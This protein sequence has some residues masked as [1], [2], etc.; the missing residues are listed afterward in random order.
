MKSLVALAFLFLFLVAMLRPLAPVLD[1]AANKSYFATVLCINKD[2]PDLECEGKCVLMQRLK[3]AMGEEEPLPT[4][5][6]ERVSMKDYPIGII[7]S[8]ELPTNNSSDVMHAWD[9]RRQPS[10]I[11]PL[12]EI[13]HPPS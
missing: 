5:P 2:K 6:V 13:L 4:K 3:Q 11:Q 1:Y 9:G 10:P 7:S 12:I 8:T